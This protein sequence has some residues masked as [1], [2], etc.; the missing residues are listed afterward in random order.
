MMTV[1]CLPECVNNGSPTSDTEASS[2]PDSVAAKK[3]LKLR[4]KVADVRFLT[5]LLSRGAIFQTL[6]V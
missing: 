2:E 3:E 4:S 6:G 5:N 1:A